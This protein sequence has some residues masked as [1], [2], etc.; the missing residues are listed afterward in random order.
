MGVFEDIDACGLFM[1]SL[2]GERGEQRG[3]AAELRHDSF[4]NLRREALAYRRGAGR[5]GA[6]EAR[7]CCAE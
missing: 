5:Q 4:F 3:K 2:K 7:C 1:P 6:A